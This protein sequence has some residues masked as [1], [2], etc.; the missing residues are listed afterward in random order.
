MVKNIAIAFAVLISIVL[1]FFISLLYGIRLGDYQFENVNIQGLYLKYDKKLIIDNQSITI[2]NKSKTKST[3]F[4]L[5]F[6]VESFFDKYFISVEQFYMFDPYLKVSGN[7]IVDPDKINLNALSQTYINNFSLQFHKRLKAVHADK[8]FVK[9][10]NDNFYFSFKNPTYADIK[11]DQSKVIIENYETLKLELISKDMINE[12]LL[13]LLSNYKINLPLKQHFGKNKTV[14]RLDIPFDIKKE[15]RAFSDINVKKGKIELYNIPLHLEDMQFVFKDNILVGKGRL[16]KKDRNNESLHY[17]I[18]TNFAI[19]FYN[20]DVVGDFAIASGKYRKL[21]TQTLHGDFHLSFED[22]VKASIVVDP[23]N[24]FVS[25]DG[26]PFHIEKGVTKYN[27][28]NKTFNSRFSLGH[29]NH[30]LEIEIDDIF[31]L[32][33]NS[34]NG[35]SKLI[36]I[37]ESKDVVFSDSVNY[38]ADFN[39]PFSLKLSIPTLQWYHDGTSYIANNITGGFTQDKITSLIK[40]LNILNSDSSITKIGLEYFKKKATVTH[41]MF[42]NHIKAI[43]DTTNGDI[44]G[45]ITTENNKSNKIAFYGN[46]FDQKPHILIPSWYA[47][48]KALDKKHFV[49]ESQNPQF[50][51][52]YFKFLQFNTNS[53]IFVDKKIGKLPVGYAEN[54]DFNFERYQEEKA[55]NYTVVLD[56]NIFW[57]NSKITYKN[58]SFPFESAQV[59]SRDNE[60]KLFLHARDGSNIAIQTSGNTLV[61]ESKN[62]TDNYLNAI[63]NK[64]LLHG[65]NIEFF[66]TKSNMDTLMGT[67]NIKNTNIRDLQIVNNLLL[68][69]NSSPILINPL[70]GIPTL[71]RLGKDNFSFDGYQMIDGSFKFIYHKS[72]NILEINELQTTGNL[73]NF[74]GNLQIDLNNNEIKGDIN[75][76][77]LKDFAS[78]AQY[79]PLVNKIILD[80]NNELSLPITISGTLQDAQFQL[81]QS[82]VTN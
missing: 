65:G 69:V 38:K 52:N 82:K 24:S 7:I 66:L 80:K 58:Y 1:M 23:K 28:G 8:C 22:V 54:I 53:S 41:E 29:L 35:S 79:I 17:D 76:A 2:Y 16:W 50:L 10:E 60:K 45:T 49:F 43:L 51:Q 70:L 30:N 21:R 36:Y 15:I 67:V 6:S 63:F 14:V 77:F 46:I 62:I 18:N 11:L 4:R 12:N 31:K 56:Y 78:I 19:N 59:I 81:K 44:N 34:S 40:Q 32:Y 3:S 5:K 25:V 47:Q 71:L 42:S 37:D 48:L 64:K 61:M 72:Q 68:F 57:E 33:S 9:Y 55:L 27:D 73:N 75:V 26:E 74:S 13:G 39:D 20:N